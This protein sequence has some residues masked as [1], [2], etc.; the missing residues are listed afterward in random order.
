MTFLGIYPAF[1][2]CVD[3]MEL[4]KNKKDYPILIITLM[5]ALINAVLS[6]LFLNLGWEM[7]GVLLSCAIVQVFSLIAYKWNFYNKNKPLFSTI[8]SNL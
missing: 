3:I 7:E 2:Y 5:I 1:L 4:L 8:E 6:Y